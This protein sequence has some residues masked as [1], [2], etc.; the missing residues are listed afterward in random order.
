MRYLKHI[1]N[2]NAGRREV[3]HLRNS[4]GKG[5]R[6]GLPAVQSL[7]EIDSVLASD[8]LILPD[9]RLLHHDYEL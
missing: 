7:V 4:T 8:D 5:N 2:T 1:Q 6:R 9:L 3:K